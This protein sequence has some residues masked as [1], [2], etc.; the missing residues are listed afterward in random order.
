MKIGILTLLPRY[1]YGGVL[2]CLA[3]QSILEGMGHEVKVI[4][5]KSQRSGTLKR[6]LKLLLTDFSFKEYAEWVRGYVKKLVGRQSDL[7]SA[8]LANCDAFTGKNLHFTSDCN[9][10]TIGTLLQEEHFDAVVIGS[11]KVWGGLGHEQLVY[12]GDWYPRF[13]GRIISY[14]ACSSIKRVPKFN[15]DKMRDL[16]SRFDAISVRDE[17]TRK[18]IEPY[19]PTTPIVVADPTVL[20][21]FNE[22]VGPNKDGDYIFAY[23]LGREIKEGHKAA[24]DEMRK[25]YGNIPVKAIMFTNQNTEIAAYADEVITDASPEKWLTL[26]AHAKMVYTDSFHA[27]IFSMKY[28]RQFL[29]YYREIDRASRLI[30]LRDSLSLQKNIVGSLTEY[31]DQNGAPD[32]ID[33]EYIEQQLNNM[34]TDSIAFISQVLG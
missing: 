15:R 27:V 28:K 20:Y 19:A 3:L 29:A 6:R 10:A 16:L 32:D 33:F 25:R 13:K 31:I 14:A 7:P 26:L 8:L 21:D 5:F 1:N 18:L 23:I 4:R 22:Y 17:H 12:F 24:I 9:E 34:K 11:D 30:A 2:Q